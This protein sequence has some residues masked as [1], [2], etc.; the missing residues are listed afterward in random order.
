MLFTWNIARQSA[1]RYIVEP[2]EEA[3]LLTINCKLALV[4]GSPVL[5]TDKMILSLKGTVSDTVVISFWDRD[6]KGIGRR[7]T[8]LDNRVFS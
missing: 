8:G 1:T 2:S 7:F 6:V 4:L 3:I 5:R